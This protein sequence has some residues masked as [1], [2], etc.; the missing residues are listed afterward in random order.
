MQWV[1]AKFNPFLSATW[2][3]FRFNNLPATGYKVVLVY[4]FTRGKVVYNWNT[5]GTTMDHI[6]VLYPG[7]FRVYVMSGVDNTSVSNYGWSINTF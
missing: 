6:G 4:D 3:R 1:G 2:V 5:Y 7:R